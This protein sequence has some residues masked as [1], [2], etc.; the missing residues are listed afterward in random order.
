SVSNAEE[1]LGQTI[2]VPIR[3]NQNEQ[4]IDAF[5]MDLVYDETMLLFVGLAKGDLT[6]HFTY[7]GG[8]E[9]ASGT[10][11]IGGFDLIPIPIDSTGI[12]AE[13]I[14]SVICEEEG[15][16]TLYLSNLKDDIEGFGVIPGI[17]TSYPHHGDVNN[18]SQITPNDALIAF[19]A[20][21][22]SYPLTNWQRSVADR[23][24]DGEVTPEDA[25]ITFKEYLGIKPLFA[26]QPTKLKTT[27]IISVKG[28]TG[29]P[30][31]SVAIHIDLES[32]DRQVD[33]F[34]MELLYDPNILVYKEA[35]TGILT[36]NP[37]F[38]D[39]SIVSP[40]T[41]RIGWFG[42]AAIS[43]DGSFLDIIFDIKPDAKGSCNLT[44]S[45]LK[46]DIK[47]AG[48]ISGKFVVKGVL[49]DNLLNVTVYPNPCRGGD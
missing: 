3:I 18:D 36:E 7:L 22:D 19:K 4:P 8:N 6:A 15:T 49:A 5:G 32:N 20:Y 43:S 31:S 1:G 11:R 26:S 39:G 45:N 14:F 2:I 42:T 13:A 28:A 9:I 37:I 33:A 29:A 27:Q 34:G 30:N 40:G 48:T 35:K 17:F 47:G 44:L 41:L 38:F 23:N 24:K 12:I 10:I 46:D 21:L 25:L 16:S